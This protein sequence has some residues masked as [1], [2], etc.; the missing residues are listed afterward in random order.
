[1]DSFSGRYRSKC[2]PNRASVLLIAL[3]TF[4]ALGISTTSAEANREHCFVPPKEKK[5]ET[6]G[7]Y[8]SCLGDF[9]CVD[10]GSGNVSG[11]QDPCLGVRL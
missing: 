6:E 3:W 1:M 4:F 8:L 10:G 2:T 7:L 5:S 11:G 9:L